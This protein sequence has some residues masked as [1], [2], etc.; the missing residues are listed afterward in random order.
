MDRHI[1]NP[2]SPI[3]NPR[4]H[5]QSAVRSPQSVRNPQS[6]IRNLPGSPGSTSTT[7]TNPIARPNPTRRSTS[8]TTRKS[9]TPMRWSARLLDELRAARQL[10]RTLVVVAADH[11]ESLGEHGERTHGVFVYD[12][13][14]AGAGVHLGGHRESAAARLTTL[15]AADRSR[16]DGARSASASPRR[17]HSKGDRCCRQSTADG[18]PP[19]RRR[20]SRRWTRTSR[21]T[22][23]R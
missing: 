9:P 4:V 17:R 3:R 18:R 19:G 21:A 5:P 1:R 7:P 10:D 22:G 20:T 16:A 13:D 8:R 6:A 23:R 14:D 12:V 15:T 11:G 2:Q